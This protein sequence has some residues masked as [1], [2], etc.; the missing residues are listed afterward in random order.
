MLCDIVSIPF[1][2][3]CSLHVTVQCVHFTG[4]LYYVHCIRAAC[5]ALFGYCMMFEYCVVNVMCGLGILNQNC[6][7]NMS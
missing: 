6:K 4:T 3:Q 1:V 5:R 7:A 2:M